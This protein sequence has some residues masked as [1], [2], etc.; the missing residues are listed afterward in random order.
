VSTEYRENEIVVEGSVEA[1]DDVSKSLE[2]T[3]RRNSRVT[4][5]IDMTADQFQLLMHFRVEIDDKLKSV[6][7]QHQQNRYLHFAVVADYSRRRQLREQS[8]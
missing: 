2:I 1:L 5:K 7:S 6:T 8:I 4:R 3:I